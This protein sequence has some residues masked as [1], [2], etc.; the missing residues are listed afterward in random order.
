MF[1][2]SQWPARPVSCL[3]VP[4]LSSLLNPPQNSSASLSSLSFF[5]LFNPKSILLQI[6]MSALFLA[7]WVKIDSGFPSLN[8]TPLQLGKMELFPSSL[9]L[10]I[11][12]PY[13]PIFIPDALIC[14]ALL[15]ILPMYYIFLK[16]VPC[17]EFS[18]PAETSPAFS[19][20][21]LCAQWSSRHFPGRISYITNSL[22]SWKHSEQC[23]LSSVK[24]LQG[25]FPPN[26][27]LN[28]RCCFRLL[29]LSIKQN[30]K[31]STSQTLN[32]K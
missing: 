27:F 3:V 18:I 15:W 10:K 30:L 20:T 14:A 6:K 26:Q 19:R 17:N 7:D 28:T 32:T 4:G 5:P 12:S 31:L 25:K 13:S 22:C 21:E 11:P 23:P 29:S 9:F 1:F 2:L 24:P 8:M 16:S